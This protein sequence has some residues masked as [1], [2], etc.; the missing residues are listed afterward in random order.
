MTD[1]TAISV[2]ERW[3][4]LGP[5]WIDHHWYG[6]RGFYTSPGL[7]SMRTVHF[8]KEHRKDIDTQS[9]THRH[10]QP[11]PSIVRTFFFDS[12]PSFLVDS[13]FQTSSEGVS[14]SKLLLPCGHQ[15]QD[16]PSM[17]CFSNTLAYQNSDEYALLLT[18]CPRDL[19][20][21]LMH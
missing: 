6:L 16:P 5:L 7:L 8:K 18:V 17:H 14:S 2:G 21:E 20:R 10:L 1:A 9:I 15:A 19:F 12:N 3:V 13:Q 11:L 4:S